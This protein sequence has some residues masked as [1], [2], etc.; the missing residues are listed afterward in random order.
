[1]R[2]KIPS[3]ISFDKK[4][5]N[6]INKH[7]L[8]IIFRELQM[9]CKVWRKSSEMARHIGKTPMYVS[10]HLIPEMLKENLLIRKYPDNPHHPAQRYRT[11]PKSG[12][13]KDC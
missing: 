2:Y 3:G 5:T 8:T 12:A 9:F 4:N 6:E 10:R 13:N 11:K 1:M 7:L